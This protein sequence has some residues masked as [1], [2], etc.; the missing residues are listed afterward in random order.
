MRATLHLVSAGDAHRLRAVLQGM[1]KRAF[2]SS[3]FARIWPVSISSPSTEPLVDFDEELLD[4][5]PLRPTR[6]RAGD[7]EN[8]TSGN[9][10]P[11]AVSSGC[12]AVRIGGAFAGHPRAA[13]RSSS[14]L[15]E[16]AASGSV[17]RAPNEMSPGAGWRPR[18]RS[19]AKKWPYELS[20]RLVRVMLGW[21][22]HR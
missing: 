13:S 21:A 14:R 1:L 15:A 4:L 7:I 8:R 5:V 12:T 20:Y 9:F 17:A 19:D 22:H 3:P 18:P 16:K 11:S 2:A 10:N 6:Q